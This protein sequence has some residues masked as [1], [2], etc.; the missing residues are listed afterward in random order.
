MVFWTEHRK[1][2]YAKNELSFAAKPAD[3]TGAIQIVALNNP[4]GIIRSVENTNAVSLWHPGGMH[5]YG[6]PTTTGTLPFLP[7]DSFLRNE[8][9]RQFELK[10]DVVK[11]TRQQPCF[12]ILNPLEIM[13]FLNTAAA[14]R[15]EVP[16]GRAAASSVW[17]K[18]GKVAFAR[19]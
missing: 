19:K 10:I 16:G 14:A 1:N 6:M 11:C 17:R 2:R 5:P 4:V 18:I 12:L 8:Q 9:K 7:S 15:S 13:K 3:S